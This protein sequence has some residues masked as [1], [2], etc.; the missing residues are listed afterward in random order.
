MRRRFGKNSEN[1]VNNKPVVVGDLRQNQ[2]VSTFAVGAIVDFLKDTVII[3][4]VDDW[5]ELPQNKIYNQNLSKLTGVEYFLSPKTQTST[6]FDQSCDVGAYKFPEKLY[7]PKCNYIFN[8]SEFEYKKGN[9]RYRCFNVG[10]NG[11]ECGGNLVASRFVV[12]CK[13]GHME[14]FP[15]SW[16]VHKGEPCQENPRIRMYQVDNRNDIN[17]LI[18]E[19]VECGLRRGIAGAFNENI[20]GGKDGYTCSGNHPHLESKRLGEEICDCVLKTRLRSSSSI[21]F[22]V[23]QSA[24]SIPPWSTRAMIIIEGEYQRLKYMGDGIVE[25]LEKEVLP[26]VSSNISLDDL[27]KAYNII[28][29]NKGVEPIKTKADVF[30][31]EYNVLISGSVEDDD[32]YHAIEVKCPEVFEEYFD[33]VVAVTKL[34]IVQAL[35]GF[36]RENPWDN[37]DLSDKRIV[38]LSEKK[39][40]WLPAVKQYGEGIFIKFNKESID[41][42]SEYPLIET[43]YDAMRETLEDT[44]Y[45]NERFSAQYVLLHTFSHLLIRQLSEVCGY[46]AATLHEKIYS[47]FPDSE[48]IAGVLIYL[49]SSDSEG[50]LGG[51]ISVAE[52]CEMFESIVNSAL[53]KALW[54]SADPLCVNSKQQGYASLNYAAC[55]DCGLLPETSCESNNV[56][57]DRV[58]V[59][60]THD[61]RNLGFMG[62]LAQSLL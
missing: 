43:R 56:L 52:N 50:S 24:L 46:N 26:K 9:S 51:L 42:W 12:C 5:E 45:K 4:G 16:W 62:K 31:D 49:A 25:Y 38:P 34:T 11:K 13:N 2:I 57:L 33:K 47:T 40:D 59:V 54:C 44:Y 17:S 27:V 15:Y 10:K 28:F 22:P 29:E 36:T 48:E 19:C 23:V 53:K 21:Y 6:M 18:V 20:F 32:E 61:N 39:K 35:C 3:A 14:D 55:H 7:C 60:G 30:L 1:T 37:E 41:E 8:A 58:A